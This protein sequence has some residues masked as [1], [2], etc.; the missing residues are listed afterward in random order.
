MVCCGHKLTTVK[1]LDC[2]RM[3]CQPWNFL[4]KAA[5]QAGATN[6]EKE[7][8]ALQVHRSYRK[9]SNGMLGALSKQR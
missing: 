7:L 3:P 6:I 2:K 1:S 9:L 4:V 5:Q 8:P